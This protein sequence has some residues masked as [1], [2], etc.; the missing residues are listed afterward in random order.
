[1]ANANYNSDNNN[2]YNKNINLNN[3]NN[4][5]DNNI[6]H[7]NNPQTGTIKINIDFLSSFNDLCTFCSGHYHNFDNLSN[8]HIGKFKQF[9]LV[10]Y[11]Y[12]INLLDGTIDMVNIR[13]QLLELWIHF[14]S[15]FTI[16][17]I[18]KRFLCTLCKNLKFLIEN[19]GKYKLNT[20]AI[21]QL[22]RIEN[23][24][25][26]KYNSKFLTNN[27]ELASQQYIINETQNSSLDLNIESP[28]IDA[29]TLSNVVSDTQ[30]LSNL[31]Q[32]NNTDFFQ[33]GNEN[34]GTEAFI[35]HQPPRNHEP[36]NRATAD[37]QLLTVDKL[38]TMLNEIKKDITHSVN[39]KLND[40]TKKYSTNRENNAVMNN[41]PIDLHDEYK[42]LEIIYNRICRYKNHILIFK[43]HIQHKTAPNALHYIR[44]PKPMIDWDPVYVEIHNQIINQAQNNIQE[45]LQT[46]FTQL[47][48]E[49]EEDFNTIKNL[50]GTNDK[51]FNS[52]WA[53]SK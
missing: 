21:T 29:N 51:N 44:F 36:V 17:Q 53:K 13:T 52:K 32:L 42:Q 46:R 38:S 45:A 23:K 10:S 35:Q 50:I 27:N 11:Q 4:K 41:E 37:S 31:N 34:T 48:K 6:I 28:N 33:N 47:I 1:M 2:M 18:D 25:L 24:L 20:E 5:Q 26:A 19:K 7:Q 43:Q 12:L 14:D 9:H 16:D 39:N 40:F 15:H 30:T 22:Q 3:N 49:N 8:H